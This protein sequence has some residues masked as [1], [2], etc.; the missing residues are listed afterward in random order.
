MAVD[1]AA[2][3]GQIDGEPQRGFRGAQFPTLSAAFKDRRCGI[4][5]QVPLIGRLQAW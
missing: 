3:P 5:H 2:R 4:G 1:I